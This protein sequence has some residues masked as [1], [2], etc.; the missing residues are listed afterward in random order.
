[1]FSIQGFTVVQ[2]KAKKSH[3]A[4]CRANKCSDVVLTFLAL[5]E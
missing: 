5:E 4:L 1:M 2:A 3:I